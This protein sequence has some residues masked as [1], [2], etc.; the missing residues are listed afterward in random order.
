MQLYHLCTLAHLQQILCSKKAPKNYSTK[1]AHK[2]KTSYWHHPFYSWDSEYGRIKKKLKALSLSDVGL[3]PVWKFWCQNSKAYNDII[4][5]MVLVR[6]KDKHIFCFVFKT[7]NKERV[8]LSVVG[9]LQRIAIYLTNKLW[10][11][12]F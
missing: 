3:W 8:T 10:N 4:C 9:Y 6:K 12:I 1:S 7:K 11:L 2:M 5:F